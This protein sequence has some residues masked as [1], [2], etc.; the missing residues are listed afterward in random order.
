MTDKT[1]LWWALNATQ[2]RQVYASQIQRRVIREGKDAGK[3]LL[4][5]RAQGL[6][7]TGRTL[8]MALETLYSGTP[9]EPSQNG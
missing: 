6:S 7:A 4:T 8:R 9:S 1:P 2:Q 3:V 5:D